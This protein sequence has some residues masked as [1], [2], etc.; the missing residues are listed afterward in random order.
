[1]DEEKK[2]FKP[3]F[4]LNIIFYI[5]LLIC[6]ATL[7]DIIPSVNGSIWAT[8]LYGIVC[9]VGVI[10]CA[11]KGFFMAIDS[12]FMMYP[13]GLQSAIAKLNRILM[14]VG[15]IVIEAALVLTWN[16]YTDFDTSDMAHLW[17]CVLYAVSLIVYPIS[18]I[19]L[20]RDLFKGKED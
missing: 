4:E 20:I 5:F 18:L 8:R 10:F 11:R 13:K 19:L 6:I 15:Y 7:A 3:S 14:L 9:L 1:M 16:I 17:N 2:E 12:F